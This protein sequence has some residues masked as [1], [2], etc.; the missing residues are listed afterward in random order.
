MGVLCHYPLSRLIGECHE[1][2]EQERAFAHHPLSH[3]DF[4]VYNVLTHQ[5]LL[6][7]EVDGWHYHQQH[8]T[9]SARDELKNE[10]LAKVDLPLHRLSTTDIVTLETMMSLLQQTL[11]IRR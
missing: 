9:Q 5:P 7:L 8:A 10:I 2:N 1:L 6:A 3:V 11:E 4:L